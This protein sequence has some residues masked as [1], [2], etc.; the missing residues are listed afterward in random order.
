MIMFYRIICFLNAVNLFPVV[1]VLFLTKYLCNEWITNSEGICEVKPESEEADTEEDS[2][3]GSAGGV[4]GTVLTS[5]PRAEK[6]GVCRNTV[7]T[8]EGVGFIFSNIG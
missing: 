2:S 4:V 3:S 8:T 1:A 6:D 5:E 7:S